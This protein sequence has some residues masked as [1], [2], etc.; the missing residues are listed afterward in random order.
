M[1]IPLSSLVS[2]TITAASHAGAL[3]NGSPWKGFD[4]FLR[5]SGEAREMTQALDFADAAGQPSRSLTAT[6]Q[7]SD[8]QAK[9]QLMDTL[10][11]T[12]HVHAISWVLN[13]TDYSFNAAQKQRIQD[14]DH[15]ALTSL[16]SSFVDKL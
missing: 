7:G 3:S 10:I 2:R 13:E 16:K 9:S 14:S 12:A 11:A 4:E 5:D 6:F 8:E 15:D 1:K